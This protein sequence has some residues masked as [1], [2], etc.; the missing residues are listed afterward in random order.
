MNYIVGGQCWTDL[1]SQKHFLHSPQKSILGMWNCHPW[2]VFKNVKRQLCIILHPSDAGGSPTSQAS[3]K[4]KG[5]RDPPKDP[6]MDDWL[7]ARFNGQ[8]PT[9]PTGS[10]A[11]GHLASYA[12]LHR[13]CIVRAQDC[14]YLRSRNVSRYIKIIKSRAGRERQCLNMFEMWRYWSWPAWSEL[15]TWWKISLICTEPVLNLYWTCTCWI[16]AILHSCVLGGSR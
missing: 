2:D 1:D 6:K 4:K 9:T 8:V 16:L 10:M 13:N 5:R 14:W 15:K 3:A 12:K 11:L 7:S